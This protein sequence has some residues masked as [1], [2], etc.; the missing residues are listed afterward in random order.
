MLCKPVRLRRR[1]ALRLAI[2]LCTVAVCRFTLLSFPPAQLAVSSWSHPIDTLV[3]RAEEE[4][5]LLLSKR[6]RNVRAAAGAYRARRGRHPPPRFDEWFRTAERSDAFVAE[7][8]FDQIYDDLEVFWAVPAADVA[9]Q[10]RDL[11]DACIVH[12]RDGVAQLDRGCWNEDWM[13]SWFGAIRDIS[14]FLPNVSIPLNMHDE[15]KLLVPWK[16]INESMHTPSRLQEQTFKPVEMKTSFT[17]WDFESREG[18]P[19]FT[20]EFTGGPFM[21]RFLSACPPNDNE[22]PHAYDLAPAELIPVHGPK[23]SYQGYVTNWTRTTDPCENPHLF[24]LHAAL[25]KPCS[26]RVATTLFPLFSSAKLPQNNDIL[27]PGAKYWEE[28]NDLFALTDRSLSPWTSMADRVVWRGAASGGAYNDAA[29]P[30]FS[31]A[32]FVDMMNESIVSQAVE[33][34]RTSSF[35]LADP[36]VY[37]IEAQTTGDLDRWIG[38]LSDVGFTGLQ[39]CSQQLP[40]SLSTHFTPQDRRSMQAQ[41]QNKYLVDLDGNSFS[42]RYRAFLQSSSVPIKTTMF[43]EWHTAR[44]VPWLH[45]VPMD[46]SLVDLYGILDYFLGPSARA[47]GRDDTARKIA[48]AG[49]RWTRW[50]LRREDMLLYVHRL[51]LEFARICDEQRERLGYVGDLDG[52][53]QRSDIS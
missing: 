31:R 7:E 45:F 26:D 11:T 32:R 24:G 37:R 47:R 14:A 23:G 53:Q 50:V 29:W 44:L 43:R 15:P 19:A 22:P 52:G 2:V 13:M 34:G 17:P 49:Q 4:F 5:D 40:A 25:V 30:R 42:G 35:R 28:N 33:A 3:S 12:V 51:L 27:L 10:S 20:P 8:L 16:K 41:F 1:H 46:G 39:S 18:S 9:R 38:R 36:Q 48:E 21:D 6:V